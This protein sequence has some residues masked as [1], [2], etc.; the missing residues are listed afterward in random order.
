MCEDGTNL[1]R[2]RR[3]VQNATVA[4]LETDDEPVIEVFSGLYV[5]EG[6]EVPEEDLDGP[7]S[8]VRNA[9]RR[10][11][12]PAGGGGGGGQCITGYQGR[13]QDVIWEAARLPRTPFSG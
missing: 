3:A 9:P 1:R 2:R 8:R 5:N 6:E 12:T 10:P 13:S 11:P 7:L 4:D